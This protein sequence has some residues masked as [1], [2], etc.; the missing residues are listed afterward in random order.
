[1][2]AVYWSV[3]FLFRSKM[4]VLSLEAAIPTIRDEVSRPTWTGLRLGLALGH[5]KG[6]FLLCRTGST[7]DSCGVAGLLNGARMQ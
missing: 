6:M 1:M 2:T 4:V 3:S 7:S 5:L